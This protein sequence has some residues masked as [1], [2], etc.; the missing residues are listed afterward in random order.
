MKQLD[1][2]WFVTPFYETKIRSDELN[3][4][5]IISEAFGPEIWKHAVI[6]F[7]FT[8]KADDY[9]VDLKERTEDIQEAIAKCAGNEVTSNIPSVAVDNKSKTTPDGNKWLGKLY[10]KVFVKMSEK[11]TIPFFWQQLKE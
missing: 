1:V 9:L 11:G 2:L 8:N 4:I 5:K 3:G 6:I 10:T 7:T